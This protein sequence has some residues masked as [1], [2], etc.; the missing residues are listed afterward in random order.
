MNDE[1]FDFCNYCDHSYQLR[2]TCVGIP[3]PCEHCCT[4]PDGEYVYAPQYVIQ[5]L[6]LT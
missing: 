5:E 1:G 4:N 2:K 3:V 6:V